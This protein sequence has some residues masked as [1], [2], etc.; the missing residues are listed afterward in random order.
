MKLEVLE[1][2]RFYHIYNRGINGCNIFSNDENRN[3]FLKQYQKYLV[4]KV[5]T[6][7]YCL[8]RNHFHFVIR[9]DGEPKEVTQGFSNFFN[10]YAKAYN[11]AE[12]RTGSLFEKHF[13]RIKVDSEKYL[14]QVIIYVNLNSQTHFGKDYKNYFFSS[15]KEVISGSFN[16][17]KTEEL[18][19]LFGGKENFKEVHDSRRIFLS[20]QL[21]LE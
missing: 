19:D 12:N 21:T 14:K 6:F 2:D 8:L 18:L 16:I 17:L 15:Y 1:K 7:A 13:R 5:S 4:D 11:K 10:S 20:E 9:I 3:Y